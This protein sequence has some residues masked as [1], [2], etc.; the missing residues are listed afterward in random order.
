MGDKKNL[1]AM[2]PAQLHAYVMAEKEHL[3]L[4]ALAEFVEM[5]PT[6]LF[7]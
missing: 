7:E 2:I 4:G 5:I 3:T 1:C 6:Q